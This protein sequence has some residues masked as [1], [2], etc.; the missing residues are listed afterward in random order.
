VAEIETVGLSLQG[1][2]ALTAG[3]DFCPLPALCVPGAFVQLAEPSPSP[4]SSPPL[5]GNE[6]DGPSSPERAEGGAEEEGIEEPP[7]PPPAEE[8]EEPEVAG[9]ETELQEG[10]TLRGAVFYKGALSF[11]FDLPPRPAPALRAPGGQEEGE[12]PAGASEP[13]L[14][15]G[16]AHPAPSP[17]REGREGGGGLEGL[18]VS[19]CASPLGG[20]E[21]SLLARL[22]CRPRLFDGAA[23]KSRRF[24][25]G[26]SPPLLWPVGS[27]LLLGLSLHLPSSF[28][29][30]L[31]FS[32]LAEQGRPC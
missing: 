23:L 17:P 2:I 31:T 13:Q 3:L 27:R 21:V 29:D 16:A 28:P 32:F 14:A 18:C 7:L 1:S 24:P 11:F 30:L 9:E 8:G 22:G 20:G 19:L 5:R 4:P 6:E 15:E 12:A 25:N 26:E 10:Q